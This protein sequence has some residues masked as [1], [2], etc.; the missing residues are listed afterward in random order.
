LQGIRDVLQSDV[1]FDAVPAINEA[2]HQARQV[3]QKA[4]NSTSASGGEDFI[5]RSE[6]RV[7]LENLR[8]NFE[9][10]QAYDR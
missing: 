6:F 7:F 4:G 2:F 5:E 3:A 10:L 1:L 8:Q 9:Y